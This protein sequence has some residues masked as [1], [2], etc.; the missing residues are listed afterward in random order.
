M[1]RKLSNW[2]RS[3]LGHAAVGAILLWVAL[4]PVDWF[5]LAWIAPLW[6]V[7]LIR[8]K[9]LDGQRRGDQVENR[10][11][12][13]SGG[14]FSRTKSAVGG[15]LC[16][17]M[18]GYRALWLVGFIFWLAAVHW[19]RLPHWTT[20][21]GWVALAFY[22]AFYLPVFIGLARVAVQR[23]R[24]PVIVAAPVVWT[25]L[26]LARGHLLSGFTMAS[27]GHTQYRWIE[28][29]QLSDLAGAYGVSFV[30]MFVAACLGRM[31][32]ND[33]SPVVF[34]PIFPMGAMLGAALVYGHLRMTVPSPGESGPKIALIQG[35]IDVLLVSEPGTAERTDKQY[36]QLSRDAIESFGPVDLIV[37]PETI[38][39]GSL[40]EFD[41]NL[42][43]PEDWVGTAEEL[44]LAIEIQTNRSR[45]PMIRLARELDSSLLVGVGTWKQGA[46]G[47]KRFNS[48]AFVKRSGEFVGRY[49][50]MQLVM[51]GEYVPFADYLPWIGH[52]LE[53]LCAAATPGETP[54]AFK[55]DGLRVSPNICFESVIP[56]LIRRQVNELARAGEEPDVL[57]NLTND[58]WFWGSSELD[59]HLVCGVFRA[60][61]CRKPFLIAANTGFSAW[62]D[63]DGRIVQRGPRRATG[64]I[65]ARPIPDTR[66]SW[67][68]EHGDW[69]AGVCLFCCVLLAILGICGRRH[70]PKV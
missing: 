21:F 1:P 39:V 10:D 11:R 3:A 54:V 70:N 40:A 7:L 60:V 57:I 15:C 5:P 62:I 38:F 4:P 34:W 19:L 43:P 50:K 61:E 20:R 13:D 25:G 53:S 66:R 9:K 51:F 46:D 41:D 65:L 26:E 58:G 35:S 32:R 23:L 2:Y 59:M 49:D 27:L 6:W 16:S 63:G 17:F 45:E 55:L 37:W 67:Y 18:A 22:M 14:L 52:L 64:T 44:K 31:I 33:D 8:R 56:H 29:I 28:L 24:V 68:L 42:P 12:P 69:P 47:V 30:L 48:A 36:R